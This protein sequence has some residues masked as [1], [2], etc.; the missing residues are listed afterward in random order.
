MKVHLD[1][2]P[3]FL[4]Q[5]VI[6]ARLGTEDELLREKIIKSVLPYIEKADTSRPPSHATTFIHRKVRDIFGF[7]P[8]KE[9]KTQYNKSA[10]GLY[11]YLKDIV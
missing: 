11:D 8:F 5:V 6:A 10:L 7:D 3:C 4:K 2:F 9:I 1:C